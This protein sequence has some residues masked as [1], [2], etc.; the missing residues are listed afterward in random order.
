MP[1]SLYFR[2]TQQGTWLC[3]VDA[4]MSTDMTRQKASP[5]DLY[6]DMQ[7][8]GNCTRAHLTALLLQ[9]LLL[10]QHGQLTDFFG[11][12]L[13]N[14]VESDPNWE[15]E[16]ALKALKH[17]ETYALNL[18]SSP[19]RDEFKNIKIYTGFFRLK[20]ALYIK[21]AEGILRLMGYVQKPDDA[22]ALTLAESVDR[23][24]ILEIA[25]MLF[26]LQAECDVYR[27]IYE[28]VKAH[29]RTMAQVH[30]CR[31]GIGGGVDEC[32]KWIQSKYGQTEKPV[33]EQTLVNIDTNDV[34][35]KYVPGRR[36]D[37][38]SS[39]EIQ[40]RVNILAGRGNVPSGHRNE[41]SLA[42]KSDGRSTS[43]GVYRWVQDS[44]VVENYTGI[45]RAHA[46]CATDDD[47]DMYAARTA[48][49]HRMRSYDAVRTT[50]TSLS[51]KPRALSSDM[52]YVQAPTYV[53]FLARSSAGI[54]NTA[55][56][57]VSIGSHSMDFRRNRTDDAQHLIYT[58][59]PNL[60]P[61][62]LST[63]RST[64]VENRRADFC[65]REHPDTFAAKRC[66]LY[67]NVD[68]S[69]AS[70]RATR[71][72]SAGKRGSEMTLL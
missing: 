68:P 63:G 16:K 51:V 59:V 23:D 53:D 58:G 42:A 69:D 3:P 15:P 6:K 52:P 62:G 5:R 48:E 35:Q 17:L 33:V 65:M 11:N 49:E 19:W 31:R 20:V 30:E 2:D 66:S 43:S 67:D 10:P 25:F 14:N 40:S 57:A 72:P 13:K 29:G 38:V 27:Q 45:T 32:V 44:A 7:H 64:D 36:T 71:E 24:Q 47:N 70:E 41:G 1:Y 61:G 60:Q 21:D 4:A 54:G 18:Y 26:M 22:M 8:G 39:H 37:E 34:T 28:R 55:R 50:G 9:I 56:S 46:S 12:L